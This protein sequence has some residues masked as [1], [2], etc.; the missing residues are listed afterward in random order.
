MTDSSSEKSLPKLPLAVLTAGSLLLELAL[1]RTLSVAL[2]YP[3]AYVCLSTAMLG[4]GAGAIFNTISPSLRALKARQATTIGGVGFSASTAIG[5]PLWNALPVDPMSL[6]T[7]ATQLFWVPLL[8]VLITLPFVFAGFFVSNLFSSSPDA[9]ATLYAY[10]LA[11]AAAGV[12]LY[13]LLVSRLGGP[14][15]VWFAAT[16]GLVAVILAGSTT[17]TVRMALIVFTVALVGAAP[18][19]DKHIP[20]RISSNKLLG[21]A[22]ARTLPRDTAWSVTSAVDVVRTTQGVSIAIDGGTA[23]T[24]LPTAN[25]RKPVEPPRGLRALP[26]TLGARRSALVIGSGGGVEV[27]A[28]LGAGVQRV[29]ALEIDPVINELVVGSLSRQIGGIFRSPAVELVTAEAR[30][31]LAAHPERFDTIMAF[32][33]ISNAAAT[34]GAMSLAE[35]YLLTEEALALLLSRL[36]DDGVL[37]MSRPEP[38]I[39]RLIAT[40]AAVW[41]QSTP[42]SEHIAVVTASEAVPDFITTLIVNKK[43]FS[44]RH[45]TSIRESTP[46]RIAYLPSGEGD[47][48]ELILAAAD[49]H[50]EPEAKARSIT[51]VATRLPYTPATIEPAT[52][53]RPF[54][55]LN[56]PW[57]EVGLREISRV[58]S[59]GVNARARL[60]DL[61]V[62]QV[63]IILLLIESSFLALVFVIPPWLTLRRSGIDRV[64]TTSAAVFFASLGFAFITV[65]VS[66]VQRF[67]RLL[68]EPGWSLVLVLGVLLLSTGTGSVLLAG[69]HRMDPSSASLLAALAAVV[70]AWVPP[71]IADVAAGFA[72]SWRVMMVIA[73]VAPV[74]LALGAPFAAGLRRLGDA[75]LVAWG[76]ALNSLLS[77]G[78]SIAALIL[79]SSLGFRGTAMVSAVVYAVGAGAARSFSDRSTESNRQT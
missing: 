70:V 23:M 41:E 75:R 60:E 19:I 31:Y 30:A 61:P 63:A 67:T 51:E 54:F 35:S 69:R 57:R 1:V 74:G 12:G 4:F 28:C 24:R 50:Q 68:G 14:G 29:L 48:H 6:G 62:S 53:D 47:L 59:S 65:E 38:Q 43:P 33:T 10:D 58:L 5:Y 17:L 78:G 76:W 15:C 20:L 39:P 9:S 37:V 72:F 73:V 66:L 64:R 7:D 13:V 21:S 25:S 16:S 3:V 36:S 26:F 18:G 11:G 45:E 32:H 27:R 42:L 44:I 55:N 77:V 71:L 79:G 52:D 49:H 22:Q 2:W 8:L 56:R 46:G 40:V 34:S